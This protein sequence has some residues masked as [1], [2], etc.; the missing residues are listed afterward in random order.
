MTKGAPTLD[1]VERSGSEGACQDGGLTAHPVRAALGVLM[2]AAGLSVTN[3][4]RHMQ[5]AGRPKDPGLGA[6]VVGGRIPAALEAFLLDD[7]LAEAV[8]AAK[9]ALGRWT[10]CW[11]A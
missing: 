11:T 2:R 4:L 10:R 6:R 7:R 3:D 1:P 5:G 8:T 9:P